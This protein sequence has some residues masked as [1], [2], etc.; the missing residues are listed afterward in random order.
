MISIE[1]E[2]RNKL[3]VENCIEADCKLRIYPRHPYNKV[4]GCLCVCMSVPRI[5]LTAE[6]IKFSFTG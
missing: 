4:R 5:L 2:Q 3:K 1:K 6:P